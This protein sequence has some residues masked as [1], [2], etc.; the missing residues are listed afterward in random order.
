MKGARAYLHVIGL[1][2]R[3]T[4]LT[5]VLLQA[6]NQVLERCGRLQAWRGLASLSDGRNAGFLL[7]RVRWYGAAARALYANGEFGH[8][9][10]NGARAL[11]RGSVTEGTNPRRR[12]D[13]GDR[14]AGLSL[15]FAGDRRPLQDRIRA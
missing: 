8:D 15:A 5:P 12:R 10:S 1:Q 6:Q 14:V 2:D 7:H 11:V 4:L 9:N 3:A 13:R